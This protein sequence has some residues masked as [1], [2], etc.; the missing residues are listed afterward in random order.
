[1]PSKTLTSCFAAARSARRKDGPRLPEMFQ[2][3]VVRTSNQRT[4]ASASSVAAGSATTRYW[5]A[6]VQIVPLKVQSRSAV[7]PAGI[8]AP[9]IVK[10]RD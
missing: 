5:P 10:S 6:T 3:V 7:V 2:R 9:P 1:M 8:S 4:P